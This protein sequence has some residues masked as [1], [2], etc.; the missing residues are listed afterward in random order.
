M[1]PLNLTSNLGV[2]CASALTSLFRGTESGMK[3]NTLL[4]LRAQSTVNLY[5]QKQIVNLIW[6]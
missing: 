4:L 2:Y 6:R 5:Q 1:T 3:I